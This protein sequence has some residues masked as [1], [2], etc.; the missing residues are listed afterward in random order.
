MD[1]ILKVRPQKK[2]KIAILALTK[3]FS[4]VLCIKLKSSYPPFGG[5]G[6][7]FSISLEV[8][9]SASFELLKLFAFVKPRYSHKFRRY[10]KTKGISTKGE[11]VNSSVLCT[12][13]Y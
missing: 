3:E 1:W 12:K 6:L 9:S 5:C 2:A 10:E 4:K 8:S 11:D 13:P 7:R